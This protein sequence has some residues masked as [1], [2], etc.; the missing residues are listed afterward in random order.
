MP[1]GKI[2]KVK[3]KPYKKPYKKQYTRPKQEWKAI[4]TSIAGAAANTTGN[5]VLI[6][7]CV[8]G[9]DIE[10][11]DGRQINLRSVELRGKTSV[12]EE[13]GVAQRHRILLVLDKNPHGT[14][15]SIDDILKTNS[16]L[17]LRNLDNRKRFKIIMDKTYALNASGEVGSGRLFKKYIKMTY[18]TQYNGGTAGTIADIESGALFIVLMG[19]KVAGI[20]AGDTSMECRVRFTE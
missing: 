11:R 13:T 16:T 20:T 8:R 12:T 17:A 5:I 6:N 3:R 2:Y 4:D 7:G 18:N 1:M 10:E 14:N 9:D 19:N 15:P